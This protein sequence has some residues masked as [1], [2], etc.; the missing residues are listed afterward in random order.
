MLSLIGNVIWFVLGGFVLGLSWW[1]CSAIAFVTIIGIPWGRACFVIGKFAFFPFGKE[2]VSRKLLN[3]QDDLGTGP[4]GMIGNII[5]FILF[6]I[7][8]AIGHVISAVLCAMTIIGIP[9]AVQHLKLAGL[10]L[11]PVGKVIVPKEVAQAL[12]AEQAAQTIR[13]ARQVP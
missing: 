7:W 11:F 10:A 5:W 8:L 12:Y 1:V 9:L 4:L 3:G 6:G 2:A 13:S